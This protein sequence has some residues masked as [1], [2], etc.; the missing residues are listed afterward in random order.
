MSQMPPWEHERMLGND[1]IVRSDKGFIKN[2]YNTSSSKD[3]LTLIL[4]PP[5]YTNATEHAS[6]VYDQRK[7]KMCKG[8]YT[9]YNTSIQETKRTNTPGQLKM[10]ILDSIGNVILPARY[11]Y[12]QAINGTLVVE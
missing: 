4:R 12:V 2:T 10:G 3:S 6:D 5:N 9:I 7:H 8:Y 11:D 1:N